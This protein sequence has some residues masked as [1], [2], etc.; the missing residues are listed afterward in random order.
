MGIISKLFGKS[1]EPP[2]DDLPTM[3]WD[4]R[5][6]IYDHIRTHIVDG[7]PGLSD[8]GNVL[9]DDARIA[10]DSGIRWA[11]GAMD[12]VMGHHMEELDRQKPVQEAIDLVRS[13]CLSPTAK[14]K[15]ALYQH[16]VAGTTLPLIDPILQALVEAQGLNHDRLYEVAYS[17]A[18]EAPD[19]EPV[20]FGL[21]I[22]GL[23]RKPENTTLLQTLG[24]H[25]EFTLFAAVALAR[26]S[27][28]PELSLWSLAKNVD[29]WGRIHTVE[30][31]ADTQNPDIKHWMLREGY[32]NWVMYEYLAH[33]C[34]T[35]GDLL[36]ALDVNRADRELLTSAGE[37][38]AALINGGPAQGI[39]DYHDGA[40]A[41][42]RFLGHM[43]RDADTLDD[44]IHIQAIRGYLSNDQADWGTLAQCG[45]TIERRSRLLTICDQ[46]LKLPKWLD[47]ARASLGSPDDIVFHQAAQVA[48]S[49]GIETWDVHWRRLHA[50]SKD[51]NC[52]YQ[53]MSRSNDSR[54]SEV[55]SYAENHI[56]LETIATGPANE[57]GFGE[58]W[59]VH[60]CLDFILQELRRFPGHGQSLIKAGLRSPVV[61]NR[62]MAIATLAAWGRER[63]NEGLRTALEDAANSEPSADVL[64]RMLKTLRGEPLES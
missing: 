1:G 60:Q 11:A 62:N 56:D 2:C 39:N 22:L 31:L 17:F 37:L 44:F 21:S 41:T 18:T 9:P 43:E 47:K 64:E 13:Y 35:T 51:T 58:G 46:I 36:A 28:N 6:S 16:V 48:E 25:E 40:L 27:E 4:Q 42:E 55:V 19:R 3:P 26:I 50:N 38:L 29:G 61:R 63:W 20:K 10:S 15:A 23:Y 8:E 59:E 24:R 32:K 30:R 53:I 54:I 5:P 52:W 34:A 33:T 49:L 7:K 12:G 45:W 14:T 57:M